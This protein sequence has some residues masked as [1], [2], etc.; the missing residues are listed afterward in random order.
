M[1]RNI[2]KGD[3]CVFR[4]PYLGESQIHE[5]IFEMLISCLILG[6]VV[7][8]AAAVCLGVVMEIGI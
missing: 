7:V 1:P 6:N 2:K 8:M 3:Q 5:D 4:G